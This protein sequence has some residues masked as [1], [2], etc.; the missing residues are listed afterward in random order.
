MSDDRPT[1]VVAIGCGPANLSLAALAAPLEELR[2]TAL[3]ARSSVAWHP[4]L[5]W[6]GSRLQVSGVKDLVSL[7]DP[8]SRFSFLNYL[9]EQGR[10]YRHLIAG[11]DHV[12]RK[13]FDQYF[14]W[15]A[16]LLDV[17]IGERVEAVEHDGDRFR[18]RTP[19]GDRRATHL[20]LGV[21][22]TPRVP[23]CA[24]GLTHP[25]L[26]HA[27]EHLTR[28]VPLAGRDVLL[29]G[30]G[31][32]AAEVALDLMSGRAGTPRRLTWATGRRGFAPLDDSPFANEWFN[33][34][35]VEYFRDLPADRR[36]ALLDRQGSAAS[37]ITREL[38]TQVYKRLYELDYL[39]DTPFRHDLLA[40]T[41]L[42]GLVRDDDG[43]R[44]T[45][46]DTVTGTR[47]RHRSDIVVLAT[48]YRPQLPS[49]M[50]PL[51]DRLSLDGEGYAVAADYRVPW[52]GPDT[53]HIHVQNAARAT[54][55]VADPNLGLAAWRSAVILNS[56]LAREHYPLKA[57]EIALGLGSRP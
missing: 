7:V 47:H 36:A 12:S 46:L 41:R 18:V 32:S 3:E 30:G 34:R 48:G 37:G 42:D 39:T 17:R 14:T 55:G 20:V 26:W 52:D 16:H 38:L 40:G 45:L 23:D 27:A 43:F 1:D 9:H 44:A 57:D 8:R 22:Q 53:Q 28:D 10:L 51:R 29:V 33:P 19:R 21:G 4:G 6:S 56:L 31:Q 5:L 50:E 13:E 24:R 11:H 2:V 54:H 25:R 35:Y 15:A 49:F